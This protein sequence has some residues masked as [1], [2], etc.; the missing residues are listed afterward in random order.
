MRIRILIVL[1]L[2][3]A[4]ATAETVY[5]DA[6]RDATLIEESGGSL[7]IGGA[8]SKS[9]IRPKVSGDL[10]VTTDISGI[11]H[12]D[13]AELVIT[14]RSGTPLRDLSLALHQ[15]DQTLLCDP[16]RFHGGGTVGGAVAGSPHTG[17][18]ACVCECECVS[19]DSLTW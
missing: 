3:P 1:L 10:L 12:Y 2:A 14:A 6:V 5:I 18:A 13:P 15:H 9:S 17:A 4:L 7:A 19:V 11:V 8:G 16:P